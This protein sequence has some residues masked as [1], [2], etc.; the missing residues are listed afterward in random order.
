MHRVAIATK[1]GSREAAR[2]AQELSEWLLRRGVELAVDEGCHRALDRDDISVY[3]PDE[4]YDLVVVLGGDGTLMSVARAQ[5][6]RVPILGVNLGTLGFLTEINR[7]ELDA[8]LVETLAGRFETESRS[9]PVPYCAQPK[10]IRRRS[11]AISEISCRC[12]PW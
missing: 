3:D 9:L 11:L 1:S 5:R 2:V 4:A 7:G 6:N 10:V 12:T 8:C